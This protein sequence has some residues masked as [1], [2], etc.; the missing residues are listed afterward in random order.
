MPSGLRLDASVD[1]QSWRSLIEL[2]QYVG[3]LYWSAGH[4]MA[5]VRSGRVELRV[6]PGGPPARYLRVTQT[7]RDP[8][9]RWSVRELFVYAATDTPSVA[10]G[11]DGPAL[12]RA[13]RA[14]GVTRLYADHGWG[15]R[16]ATADAGIRV[17]PAN[18]QLDAYGFRGSPIDLLP[19]FRW[20]PGSGALV[21]PADA[22]GFAGGARVAGLGFTRQAVGG[23]TLF[24]HAP[25]PGLP[26]T[27]LPR[28]ALAL[29]ASRHPEVAPRALDGDPGTRWATGAPQAPGDWVR[30]DL[31]APRVVRAVRLWTANP[32]DAPRGLALEGSADGVTWQPI[33]AELRTDGRLRW[34]G[35]ALLRDGV[36]GVRLDFA[37]APLRAL[38]L[39]L[40]RGDPVFDW[41]IHELTV[42]AAD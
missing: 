7:G 34:G 17:P 12:A 42:Y 6:P 13:I 25:V 8:I 20:V 26:G 11:A 37:P 14:A 21:E 31:A 27:P 32:T 4:P 28:A 24:A 29:T 18:L 10:P 15:A 30:I 9:W 38:R 22:E 41:S 1:G 36:E 16:A 35:I 23:L 2:P 5:R 33:A 3:P 40:T 39:V 19:P